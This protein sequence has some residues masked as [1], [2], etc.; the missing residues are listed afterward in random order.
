[1][2]E[3]CKN[4]ANALRYDKKEGTFWCSNCGE[5]GSVYETDEDDPCEGFV[6]RKCDICRVKQLCGLQNLLAWAKKANV[7]LTIDARDCIYF[8][9]KNKK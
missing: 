7:K 1:M 6:P 4:C 2:K 9:E 3:T 8:E 5:W